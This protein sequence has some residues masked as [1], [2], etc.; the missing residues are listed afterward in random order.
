LGW[1]LKATGATDTYFAIT[2]SSGQY[3]LRAIP[4]DYTLALI[5]PQGYQPLICQN[6]VPINLAQTGDSTVVDFLAQLPNP[7]CPALS[8]SLSTPILRRCFSNNSYYIQY[9]NN[10]PFEAPDAYVTLEL[11]PF[12]V[13][14][15][16]QVPYT[17]LG[18]NTYRFD[19]GT[20]PPNFCD[21]IWVRVLVSCSAVLG[22][23]HCSEAHIY[24]DTSCAP[25]NPQW[26]GAHIQVTSQC[27]GDSLH[28]LLKNI[29]SGNMTNTLEYIVIEDGIMSQQGSAAPLN[30][31]ESMTVSVP[32][33]GA[34]WRIETTQE[35]FSPI[36]DQPV[37]S[38][39]GC[40]NTGS[41]S[42][43]FVNQFPAGDL[44]PWVDVDCTPNI[45]SYDPNDK[46][47]FPL[48]Y[49]SEHYIRPGTELEYLI[50]FQNTG[51][52][53]AFTV[54]IRDTL[55][56]WLDPL[57]V[58]AGASSHPYRFELAGTGTLIFEFQNI[59]LP[60]STVN[61]PESHG[62]VQFRISPRVDVPLETAILNS[63][64]IYFDFNDPVLTNTTVHRLG[65]N[66]VSVG[67]WQAQVPDYAVRVAPHPMQE[68]SWIRLSPTV[69]LTGTFKLRVFDLMGKPAYQATASE[70]QFLLRKSDLPAGVYFF[71]IEN[72][73]V[74]L[75]SGKL[76]VR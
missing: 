74:L 24:P 53:T 31:G 22:Q 62:F 70:A 27:A 65:E 16:A 20:V 28:F 3:L 41:F 33:N 64:A 23:T 63:A 8:V 42:M 4:G 46:Q 17:D 18:N 40:T 43:G 49:G 61:E 47:G 13:I 38:V 75:G 59:L 73:G 6:D 69:N 44:G 45:G 11:D 14:Q 32:A 36:P 9:C 50:R 25:G 7:D 55:S 56:A 57:T 39:E 67:L 48:G 12:L 66:F 52:D 54:V 71:N 15:N 68:V 2:D 35:P 34:T 60:D 5:P 37:L 10:S 19:L 26:S 76:I 21:D 72:E 51:T 30:A 58:R 29:G 1:Y